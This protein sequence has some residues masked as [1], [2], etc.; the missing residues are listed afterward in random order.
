MNKYWFD[1]NMIKGRIAETLIEQLFDRMGYDVYR[2]G[3]ENTVPGIMKKL[4][5]SEPKE[6]VHEISKMPDFIVK[7]PEEKQIHYIEV[8]FR[9]N[10]KF[11][12][13]DLKH[14]YPYKNSYF[15][16]VSKKHIKCLSY[17]E[18][19]EGKEITPRS[20]NFLGSRDDFKTDKETIIQFCQFAVKFF[21]CV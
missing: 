5:N 6:V 11:S 2:Y 14:G 4:S 20:R 19:E 9:A 8:K 18:L 1:E 3:M 13:D 17:S 21:E 10:G 15:I 16:V 12:F 7:H